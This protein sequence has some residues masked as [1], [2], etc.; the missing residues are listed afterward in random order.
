MRASF[1]AALFAL[2]AIARVFAAPI[3]TTWASDQLRGYNLSAALGALENAPLTLSDALPFL[4]WATLDDAVDMAVSLSLSAQCKKIVAKR[5][6]WIKVAVSCG[7]LDVWD[8]FMTPLNATQLSNLSYVTHKYAD[9]I[10]SVQDD[11]RRSLQSFWKRSYAAC[12]N[13]TVLDNHA[14][15]AVVVGLLNRTV[16]GLTIPATLPDW[17]SKSSFLLYI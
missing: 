2:F 8:A 12:G 13:E 5:N 17:A 7:A 11:C 9:P 14:T 3:N 10:C 16:P 4:R 15:P 1:A 6:E